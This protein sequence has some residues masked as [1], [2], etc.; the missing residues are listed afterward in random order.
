[1][2]GCSQTWWR[3]IPHWQGVTIHGLITE[4]KQLWAHLVLGWMTIWGK[5]VA[6]ND[7][8]D[9]CCGLLWLVIWACK[10]F[11]ECSPT[12][13]KPGVCAVMSMW[14][15][16][17][18]E[19]MWSIR[20]CPTTMLLSAMSEFASECCTVCDRFQKEVFQT[21]DFT[22]SNLLDE[23]VK[24]SK[25]PFISNCYCFEVPDSNLILWISLKRY[26]LFI[27]VGLYMFCKWLWYKCK[28]VYGFIICVISK[29][30]FGGLML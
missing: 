29:L 17:I 3:W 5:L 25:V 20:T 27:C 2:L 15:V 13:K 26:V 14:L 23:T 19:C 12:I 9:A 4:V 16:H 1:M 24:F 28:G 8:I 18:K 22:L 11:P 6:A 30:N 21:F 7:V 10:R